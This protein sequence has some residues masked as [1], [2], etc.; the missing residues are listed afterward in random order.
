MKSMKSNNLNKVIKNCLNATVRND[1]DLFYVN[2]KVVDIFASTEDKK[3]VIDIL[4]DVVKTA[5]EENIDIH[6]ITFS[7]LSE[8][9][10]IDKI[11]NSKI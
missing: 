11:I 1:K 4:T 3:V 7:D 8:K 5:N 6:S 2:E 9:I 10:N